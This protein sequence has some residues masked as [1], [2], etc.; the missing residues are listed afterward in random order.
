M[1][2]SRKFWLKFRGPAIEERWIEAMELCEALSA[3]GPL[4][5]EASTTVAGPGDLGLK[6]L[7]DS[8]GGTFEVAFDEL[9]SATDILVRERGS[10]ADNILK[11]IGV[12][13]QIGGLIQLV[14]KL[15]GSPPTIANQDLDSNTITLKLGRLEATYHA[16]VL[17][18]FKSPTAIQSLALLAQPLKRPG[19]EN[20]EI[21]AL[22]SDG[23]YICV[24]VRRGDV[25]YFD[26]LATASS[27][28]N[29]KDRLLIVTSAKNHALKV[30]YPPNG[31]TFSVYL[32]D[33]EFART[34]D[35]QN[36]LLAR[37]DLLRVKFDQNNLSNQS[38]ALEPQSIAKVVRH[39][40]SPEQMKLNFGSTKPL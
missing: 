5:E 9:H 27:S 12:D 14:Q 34:I 20:M 26:A 17:D 33:E 2:D 18:L 37:G 40:P 11:V 10:H 30:K 13:A 23:D 19:V 38:I 36:I 21:G 8:K 4:L 24:V 22:D 15:K 25:V 28:E 31:Q 16:K 3:L 7:A 32:N 39:Y 1:A 6:V 29:D 35:D